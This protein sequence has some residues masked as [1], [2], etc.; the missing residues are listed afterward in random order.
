MEERAR[1]RG[2]EI[3]AVDHQLSMAS[4]VLKI[5][6]YATQKV[7]PF[8]KLCSVSSG[9]IKVFAVGCGRLVSPLFKFSLNIFFLIMKLCSS[10]P[11]P[12]VFQDFFRPT[13]G[14]L[15][16]SSSSSSSFSS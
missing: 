4:D 1:Y 8:R 11:F 14:A 13:A 2:S 9:D 7:F 3:D 15:M 16:K 6:V 5:N 10:S 12:I